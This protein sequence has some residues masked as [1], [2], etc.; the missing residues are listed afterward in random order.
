MKLTPLYLSQIIQQPL[1]EVKALDLHKKEITHV[2]DISCCTDLRKLDLSDNQIKSNEVFNGIK[3]N[4]DLTW[5]NL[6]KN[7]LS[8]IV[9]IENLQNL[10]ILNLGYN[11]LFSIPLQIESCH[12]L[13]ALIINNNSIA[14]LENIFSFADLNTIVASHNKIESVVGLEKLPTLTKLSISDNKLRFFPNF[15]PNENLKEVRINNNKIAKI[16]ATVQSL[17]NLSV[18]DLGNNLIAK[19]E[20]IEP[21]FACKNLKNLNLVGNPITKLPEYEEK[22]K[23]AFPKLCILDG[24][25]FDQKFKERKEKRKVIQEIKEREAKEE[26]LGLP[27]GSLK[28][29]YLEKAGKKKFKKEKDQNNQKDQKN[30]NPVSENKNYHSNKGKDNTN[31]S[32]NKHRAKKDNN[33]NDNK[34]RSEFNKRQGNKNNKNVNNLYKKENPL[35]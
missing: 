15:G 7:S 22:I 19:W 11:E 4:K 27:K 10:T 35:K 6:S 26:E 30:K 31:S 12:K 34:N 24:L 1:G 2:E 21:L 25:R 8:S 17:L 28:N 9:G 29:E 33:T 13:K 16:P 3:Y 14:A 23:Q 32:Y 5:L 18:L 20:H